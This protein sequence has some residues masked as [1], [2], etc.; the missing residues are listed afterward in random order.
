MM[1]IIYFG[2]PFFAVPSVYALL[3]NGADIAAV[4][5]QPDKI[6]GRGHKLSQPPVKET[7]LSEGI[8]VLQPDNIRTDDFYVE[9]S[10]YIPECIIVVAY[11]KIIPPSI[12]NLPPM[13]CVNVHASVLPKYRG[14]APIQWALI[15]GEKRTGITTMMMDKG[16]DTG[17]ILMQEEIEIQKEDNAMTLSDKLSEL[18]A[19]LLIKTMSALY[20]RTIKPFPQSGEP[21]Y[22]PPLRKESG[23]IDW[24]LSADEINNLIRGTYPWPGAYFYLNDERVG[25]LKAGI[26]D[27]DHNNSPGRIEEIGNKE[28]IVSTGKGLLTIS[29]VRPQGKQTM[30]ATA[31]IRGRRLQKG[32]FFGV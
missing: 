30:D 24:T 13:G 5:T 4:V 12:L 21:T 7:A 31:F 18:G 25:I 26:A 10:K 8:P 1:R 16:M 29:K 32:S 9:I 23:R 17:D 6:K 15:N 3:K 14:A 2:T 28:I 19:S 20:A 11:G 22:A 27:Y